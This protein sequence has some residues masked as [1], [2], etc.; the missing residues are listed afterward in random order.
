MRLVGFGLVAALLFGAG[1]ALQAGEPGDPAGTSKDIA[2][3]DTTPM[4]RQA[5]MSPQPAGS[6]NPEPSPWLPGSPATGMDEQSNGASPEP[7]PW[8]PDTPS[9]GTTGDQGGGGGGTSTTSGSAGGSTP[10]R[11]GHIGTL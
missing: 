6:S 9:E 10:N 8:H 4:V 2:T 5:A 11:P 1:C 7:S 3:G